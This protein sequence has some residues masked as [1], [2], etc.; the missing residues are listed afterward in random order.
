VINPEDVTY[1]NPD[2]TLLQRHAHAVEA[3]ARDLGV[4]GI[5]TTGMEL[6]RLVRMVSNLYQVIV[7]DS[8]QASELSGPRWGLLMRLH[9]EE[10]AG[11]IE[12][13]TPTHLS[14]SQRVSKNTISALLRGLE[15]QGL[16]ERRSDPDDLRGFRIRLTDA[17]RR[18]VAETAPLHLRHLNELVAGLAPEERGELID[19][20][21]KL[22][23]ELAGR[24]HKP[25]E[26]PDLS[27]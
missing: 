9:G 18:L 26:F 19:L 10:F 7:D 14:R 24:M 16:V 8:L 25:T 6:A 4:E 17:G 13:C 2:Q 23:R 1:S 21:Q 20:L 27:S 3:M 12:G 11:K 5:D 22:Y 15:E